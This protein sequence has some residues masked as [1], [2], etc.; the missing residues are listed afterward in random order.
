M[1]HTTIVPKNEIAFLPA[2]RI[3]ELILGRM[4]P[5]FVENRF[6]FR[7]REIENVTIWATAEIEGCPAGDRMGP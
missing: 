7:Y 3:D 1:H 5:D 4:A 6:A 2:M